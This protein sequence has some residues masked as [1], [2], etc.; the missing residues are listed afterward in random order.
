MGQ[1]Y[2]SPCSSWLVL[3]ARFLH[4]SSD[5]LTKSI[6]S[7][8]KMFALKKE[9][10]ESHVRLTMK[11]MK[12]K[13]IKRLQ[14]RNFH[15]KHECWRWT[16]DMST[17]DVM[18]RMGVRLI[19]PHHHRTWRNVIGLKSHSLTHTPRSLKKHSLHPPPHPPDSDPD[20]ATGVLRPS[21]RQLSS[22]QS[23]AQGQTRLLRQPLG[24]PSTTP[25]KAKHVP[26]PFSKTTLGSLGSEQF[27]ARAW[28]HV[29]LFTLC[30]Y[31]AERSITDTHT[32]IV[33]HR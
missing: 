9:E 32:R 11:K 21:D 28:T 2:L 15:D 3:T 33:Q 7:V 23:S 12:R 31:Q 5:F 8:T 30:G 22:S 1:V 4:L 18:F 14:Y 6:H 10:E 13:S 17:G 24:C 20:L 16:Q 25:C 19:P 27:K 29:T 26:V